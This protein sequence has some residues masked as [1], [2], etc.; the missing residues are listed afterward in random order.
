VLIKDFQCYLDNKP[1]IILLYRKTH[2]DLVYDSKYFEKNSK[3]LCY[4][5]NLDE[6]L[7]VV[8]ARML[9]NLK[10]RSGFSDN[11]N[12]SAFEYNNSY[13]SNQGNLQNKGEDKVDNMKCLSCEKNLI[14]SNILSVCKECMSNELVSQVMGNYMIFLNESIALYQSNQEKNIPSIFNHCKLYV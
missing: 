3:E 8:D 13:G 6:N 7:K 1:D 5:V 9:S 14:K 2:Y 10:Y 4:Y 12:S 11:Y